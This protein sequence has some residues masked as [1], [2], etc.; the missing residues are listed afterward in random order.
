VRQ[1]NLEQVV[2]SQ[3]AWVVP[4][5]VQLVDESIVSSYRNEYYRLRYRSA[6]DYPG[7]ALIDALQAAGR[8]HAAAVA[9]SPHLPPRR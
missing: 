9:G 5:V 2:T 7:R 6:T 8:E 4:Y 3:E 1:R